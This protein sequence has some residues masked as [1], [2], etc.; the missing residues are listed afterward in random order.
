M[1]SARALVI[2]WTVLRRNGDTCRGDE[3]KGDE[4]KG[5]EDS[6]TKTLSTNFLICVVMPRVAD[7]TGLHWALTAAGSEVANL[8]DTAAACSMERAAAFA[9][10]WAAR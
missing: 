6:A 10:D 1:L 3:D 7:Q 4:D 8:Q 9:P 2:V 5:D